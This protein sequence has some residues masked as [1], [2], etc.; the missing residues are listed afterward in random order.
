MGCPRCDS[1]HLMIRNKTGIE[2][3]LVYITKLRKY[4][5]MGCDK[6]FRMTDRC[7]L[8]RESPQ[9]APVLSRATDRNFSAPLS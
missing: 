8:P 1:D 7:R 2:R 4:R 9:E 6:V 3:I 5:C